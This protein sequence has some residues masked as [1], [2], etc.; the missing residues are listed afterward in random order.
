MKLTGFVLRP[1][2]ET[3]RCTA[4][5]GS[6]MYPGLHC[7]KT[8]TRTLSNA[9]VQVVGVAGGMRLKRACEH[10]K[11]SDIFEKVVNDDAVFRVWWSRELLD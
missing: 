9:S 3:I 8:S 5:V 7:C 4:S 10:D 1:S 6:S 2:D 11:G